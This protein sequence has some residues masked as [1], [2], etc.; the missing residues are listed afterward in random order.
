MRLTVCVAA[1]LAM[2]PAGAAAGQDTVVVAVGSP[3]VDGTVFKPHAARVRIYNPQGVLT[4]EW[5][6]ELRVG[7]S[8]G[9]AVARW[10]TTGRPVPAFPNRPLLRLLQTFDLKTV[11]PLGYVLM[12]STGAYTQLAID[13]TRV[14]GIKRANARAAVDTVDVTLDRAGFMAAASDLVPVAAGLTP[15]QVLVAPVWGPQQGSPVDHVFVVRGDSVVTVEGKP[16]RARRVDEHERAGGKRTA[17]WWL[18]GERPY[19]VYGEVPGEA[20]V[21]RITEV[22]IPLDER[23]QP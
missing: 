6:N 7:D 1:L 13:G 21:T 18:L 3:L 22:G 16:V 11:A 9:R 2:G 14:R 5:D 12:S 15:G 23:E 8:A 19:M 10:I 20:G 4:A 17:S